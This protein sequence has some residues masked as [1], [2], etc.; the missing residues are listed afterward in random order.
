[1]RW[2]CSGGIV[3]SIELCRWRSRS[4]D[5]DEDDMWQLSFANLQIPNIPNYPDFNPKNPPPYKLNKMGE[6]KEGKLTAI[7]EPNCCCA[8]C[9]RSGDCLRL[10]GSKVGCGKD[11]SNYQWMPN[12]YAYVWDPHHRE[13]K[14]CRGIASTILQERNRGRMERARREKHKLTHQHILPP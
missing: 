7:R 8:L 1:M 4:W 11:E 9:R 12:E 5:R 10:S 14:A 3:G 6:E 13:C 2:S